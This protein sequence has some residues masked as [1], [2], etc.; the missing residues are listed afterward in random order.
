[1]SSP[2]QATSAFPTFNP[3][4]AEALVAGTKHSPYASLLGIE[5]SKFE[6]GMCQ[7]RL[8]VREDVR[9]TVHDYIA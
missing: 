3:R 6:P 2:E 4:V 1:M 5:V 7:C 9:H 8:P